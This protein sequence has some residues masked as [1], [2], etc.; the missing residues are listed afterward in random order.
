MRMSLDALVERAQA[1]EAAG[2]GGIALM[3]HL[4]PPMAEDQPMYE[5]MITATWLAA[6][7]QRLG[8]G[9]LV[10]C[11]SLRH[12]AVLAREAVSIDHASG[13]RFEL[14]I[15]WGSVPD[16]LEAYGVGDPAAA[17]RV[18]RLAESLEVMTALWSGEVVDFDGE[19][20]RVKGG[21]QQPVPTAKI[22]LLIGGAGRKTLELVAR[23]ADWWNLPI[24]ALER[25][26]ELRPAVDGTRVSVQQLV[27]FVPSEADRERVTQLAERRFGVYGSG[28]VIGDAG[29]LVDHFGGLHD[30]GVERFYIWF[31]DFAA[32]ETLAAFGA[33]VIEALVP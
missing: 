15:G 23:Y 29:K 11:D 33:D 22:P 16:E 20:H 32:P 26:E 4:A 7:T 5:A 2:F 6:H 18:G 31:S 17:A 10:L 21:R 1:A 27:A 19:F 8:V 12:P 14:G 9:H 13:G 30:R 28:L 24:Y 3:D 25:L